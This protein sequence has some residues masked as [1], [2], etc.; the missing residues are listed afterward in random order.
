MKKVTVY[1]KPECGLCDEALA[2]LER[3]RVRRRFD[4][5]EVDISAD[6]ELR[7]TYGERIPVVAVDGVD[8]FDYFVDEAVLEKLLDAEPGRPAPESRPA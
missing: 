2:V 7:R 3:V 4:L 8:V 1:T 6:A 5:D